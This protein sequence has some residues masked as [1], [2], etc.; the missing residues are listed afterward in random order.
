MGYWEDREG[1][2]RREDIAEAEHEYLRG[3]SSDER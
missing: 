2:E 1:D 3:A